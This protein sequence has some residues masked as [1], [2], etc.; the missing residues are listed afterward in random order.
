MYKLLDKLADYDYE[1]CAKDHKICT[2]INKHMV[3]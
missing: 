2:K 1:Q 3:V